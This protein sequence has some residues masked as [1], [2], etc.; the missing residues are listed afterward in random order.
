MQGCVVICWKVP[1]FIVKGL[2]HAQ[3]AAASCTLP[4]PLFFLPSLQ[5]AA[6]TLSHFFFFPSCKLPQ[7]L[8]AQLA[9]VVSTL[10]L[11]LFFLFCK[12]LHAQTVA[13]AC[14]HSSFILP[15]KQLHA[16]LAAAACTAC[17]YCMHTLPYSP[18]SCMHAHSWQP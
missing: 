16:Q 5:A 9:A 6:S 13:T 7:Q 3:L 8:Y 14:M 4:L 1:L 17:C 12:L 18:P 2:V 15:G 10:S 11:P